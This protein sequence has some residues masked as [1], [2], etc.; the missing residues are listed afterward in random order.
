M[1]GDPRRFQVL[2]KTLLSIEQN[3]NQSDIPAPAYWHTGANWCQTECGS[4]KT[5]GVT[6]ARTSPLSEQLAHPK[7][8][9]HTLREVPLLRWVCLSLSKISSWISE[10]FH[11]PSLTEMKIPLWQR[12]ALCLVTLGIM[13]ADKKLTIYHTGLGCSIKIMFLCGK[14]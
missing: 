10:S 14:K 12:A 7:S 2:L 4:T 8:R 9:A 11:D 13:Y 1:L 5:H 3:V 6:W